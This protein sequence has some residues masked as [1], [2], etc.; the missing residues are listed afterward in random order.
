MHLY[1]YV[2]ICEWICH[3]HLY[4][5][6]YIEYSFSNNAFGGV[7]SVILF[8]IFRPML[9]NYKMEAKFESLLH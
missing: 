3:I 4:A 7:S 9:E 8:I 1:M 2:S 6:K 5:Y